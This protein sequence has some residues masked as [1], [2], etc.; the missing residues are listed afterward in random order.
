MA[1]VEDPCGFTRTT[2]RNSHV[3]A[4]PKAPNHPR[5]DELVGAERMKLEGMNKLRPLVEHDGIRSD[6]WCTPKAGD[7][8]QAREDA[9]RLHPKHSVGEAGVRSVAS[10]RSSMGRSVN[11][12]VS[13]QH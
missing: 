2:E 8:M 11:E 10:N 4:S 3:T 9:R 12:A 1:P 7:Y 5:L 6:S 13:R